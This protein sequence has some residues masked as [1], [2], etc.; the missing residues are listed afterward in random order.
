MVD[1]LCHHRSIAHSSTDTRLCITPTEIDHM[2]SLESE[3]RR[4]LRKIGF[5]ISEHYQYSAD[6]MNEF[7]FE[8]PKYTLIKS[9]IVMGRGLGNCQPIPRQGG[10]VFS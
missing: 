5:H 3:M 10:F 4:K 9:S 8:L 2:R 1:V 6:E 7:H